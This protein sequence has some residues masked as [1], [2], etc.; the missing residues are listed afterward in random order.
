MKHLELNL[1]CCGVCPYLAIATFT[2]LE[3]MGQSSFNYCKKKVGDRPSTSPFDA[4][5]LLVDAAILQIDIIP[6]WC[7]LPDESDR[8]E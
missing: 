6:D 2:S 4:A 1:N 3:L 5:Q 8:H 7:P